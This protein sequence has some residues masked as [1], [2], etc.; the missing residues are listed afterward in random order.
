MGKQEFRIEK[1]N[2]VRNQI[3]GSWDD[4]CLVETAIPKSKNPLES[5]TT[6]KNSINQPL[7]S[8]LIDGLIFSDNSSASLSVNLLFETISFAI[9][10]SKRFTISSIALAR[11]NLNSCFKSSGTSIFIEMSV[12]A[13]EEPNDSEYLNILE[14][15]NEN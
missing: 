11:F 10:S 2:E 3:L 15:E 14:V 1:G 6:L 9:D 4:I 7:Y 5:I 8:L 12:S 13:I